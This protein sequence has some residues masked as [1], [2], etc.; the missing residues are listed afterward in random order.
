VE[1]AESFPIFPGR[2]WRK[3][4][5]PARCDLFSCVTLINQ[6]C[7]FNSALPRRNSADGRYFCLSYSSRMIRPRSHD[8]RA[9]CVDGSDWIIDISAVAPALILAFLAAATRMHV[10]ARK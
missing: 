9:M 5:N 2:S 4:G 10:P 7:R 3:L 1:Q 6:C 8:L